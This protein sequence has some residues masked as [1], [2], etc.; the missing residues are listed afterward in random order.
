MNNWKPYLIN[1]FFLLGF[2]VFALDP[3]VYCG[4]S[5]D[6]FENEYYQLLPQRELVKEERLKLFLHCSDIPFCA[7]NREHRFDKNLQNWYY[8]FEEKLEI[9][10]LKKLVYENDLDWYASAQNKV[11]LNEIVG[12]KKATAFIS[13]IIL[14]KK[15]A[16]TA[17][18][19]NG[20]YN[21]WRQGEQNENEDNKPQLLNQ[22]I[23]LHDNEKFP[24]LKQRYAFQM[25]RL[26]H[27]L[28]NAEL[29]LEYFERHIKFDQNNDYNYYL[30]L[31][32]R[33]GAAY[34]L[35]KDQQ[36]IEGFLTVFENLPSRSY[37]NALSLRNMNWQNY[38]AVNADAKYQ[39]AFHFYKAYYLRATAVKE[40]ENLLQLNPNS[41]YLTILALREANKIQTHIF[42]AEDLSDTYPY[43]YDNSYETYEND[44]AEIARS[45]IANPKTKNKDFWRLILALTELKKENES[46]TSVI[47]KQISSEGKAKI[48]AK[49]LLF[50]KEVLQIKNIE[51]EKINRLFLRLKNNREL[52]NS[53]V[54]AFF[55]NHISNIYYKEGNLL[56]GHLAYLKNTY[57]K[58]GRWEEVTDALNASKLQF[59]KFEFMDDETI[60][61]KFHQFLQQ[62][63]KTDYEQLLIQQSTQKN[64]EDYYFDLKGTYLLS[65]N[66][67]PEAIYYFKK[68]ENPSDYYDEYYRPE[69]FSGAIKEYFNK[70]FEEQADGMHEKYK[71]LFEADLP[72]YKAMFKTENRETY[73]DNKLKLAEK[74]LELEKLA[75]SDTE[76]TADYYYMLGNAWYNLSA[77]GWFINT[78]FYTGN[79]SRRSILG[80]NDYEKNEKN[81]LNNSPKEWANKY[82][83]QVLSAKGSKE[84]RA[85]A[86]FM[87]AKNNYCYS[88]NDAGKVQVCEEHSGYFQE[89][90]TTYK[91][92][93]FENEVIKECSWYRSYLD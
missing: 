13:Y 39:E 37:N 66:Q 57:L 93:Q 77:R 69:L 8:F 31:E 48:I 78:L 25:I 7:I 19:K 62:K 45:L 81:E 85:K 73:R 88:T 63:N 72:R 18:N 3:P 70:N 32:Q 84:S 35:G 30:A 52:Y 40:M 76:N 2:S 65:L 4:Y 46:K 83:D 42:A 23:S 54:S 6:D 61:E 15:T 47:L 58:E 20:N 64:L 71:S 1:L 60:L 27:Y 5:E 80:Y 10:E 12:V 90:N 33:S 68:I 34:N 55:F 87:L 29:A 74:L 11:K 36:A 67:L 22:A 43:S 53:S 14:A 92:T 82:Y 41:P 24:F 28:Q 86:T 26:A 17:S 44:L 59:D 56:V 16:S 91:N 75:K 38:S 50:A 21:T 49:R 89:L 51:R 9:D 79:N